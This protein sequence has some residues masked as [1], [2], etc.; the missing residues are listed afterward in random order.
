MTVQV[1]EI[2][3]SIDQLAEQDKQELMSE[4]LRRTRALDFPPLSDEELISAA[5][6]V[7]L[8][9]DRDEAAHA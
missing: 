3:C 1:Q 7:F 4:L 8:Q 5:A 9:L 2:L 6:E